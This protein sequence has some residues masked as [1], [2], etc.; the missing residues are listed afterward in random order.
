MR[1]TTPDEVR[2]TLRAPEGAGAQSWADDTYTA[3]I[4]DCI[5]SAE[6]SIDTM[7]N[8]W[9][10]FD[11]TDVSEDRS[12]R[13][14][15]PANTY[16][17]EFITDPFTVVP[18]AMFDGDT[19]LTAAVIEAMIE[20]LTGSSGKNLL[21]SGVTLTEGRSYRFGG[22]TWEWAEV[23][24]NVKLAAN[25]IAA[26]N[27]MALRNTQGVLQMPDGAAIYEPRHDSVVTNWLSRW[28]APGI[29]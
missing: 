18:T 8:T 5:K 9:A 22:G 23:P 12:F 7:C 20:P 13:M 29:Y 25:R 3:L 10:P 14:D 17:T 19:E 6:L 27:F 26:R 4:G 28:M 15:A 24:P 21:I 16:P 1:Y 11:T 2:L